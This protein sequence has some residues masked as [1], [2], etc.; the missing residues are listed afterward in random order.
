MRLPLTFGSPCSK[1]GFTCSTFCASPGEA[2]SAVVVSSSARER[3]RISLSSCLGQLAKAGR[4]HSIRSQCEKQTVF[5]FHA[6][7]RIYA[8]DGRM[9]GQKKGPKTVGSSAPSGHG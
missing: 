8:K 7:A 2:P 4:K 1:T 3:I 9:L 5:G 6:C